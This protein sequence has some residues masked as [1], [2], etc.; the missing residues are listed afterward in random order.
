MQ[1]TPYWE[2]NLLVFTWGHGEDEYDLNPYL[3]IFSFSKKEYIP[4]SVKKETKMTGTL[5]FIGVPSSAGAHAPGQEKAPEY[6]R[7]AGLVERLE[8]KNIRVIDHGDLPRVRFRPDKAHRKQQNVASVL[9]VATRVAEQVDLALQKYETLLV[10]G[11]DC[12]IELGVLSGTLRH[13]EDLGLLYFDANTDL[14]IPVS[15]PGG[16]LDWMG[17]AHILGEAGAVETLSH[18]GPR[19]P[20]L[21]DD[22]VLF[23]AYVPAELTPWEQAVFARRSLRG[24]VA[25]DVVGRARDA[26]LEAVADMEKRAER[27]LVHFD[28]DVIDFLDFPIADFPQPHAVFPFREAMACLKVFVSSPKCA[29]LTITEFN[30]DHADEDG[31]LAAAF[32]EGVAS[33]LASTK[34]S[35]L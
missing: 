31:V 13:G 3:Q 8:A 18:I 20:L 33:A 22:Q 32:V 1:W 4:F 26:A 9:E 21:S 24:Y 25:D 16:F 34:L 27:F 5:G 35:E 23:F 30:P 15:E 19:F 10:L 12:T 28:V 11:G 17:M 7:G 2:A 6:L 14:N 29:G